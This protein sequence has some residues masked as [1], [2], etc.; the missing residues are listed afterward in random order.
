MV[1]LDHLCKVDILPLQ[2]IRDPSS[3]RRLQLIAS[4]GRVPGNAS[5]IPEL[6]VILK[7]SHVVDLPS[8][9]LKVSLLK[10]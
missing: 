1:A 5:S 8:S 9:R 10:I 6:V 3:S 7:P 2:R 4:F